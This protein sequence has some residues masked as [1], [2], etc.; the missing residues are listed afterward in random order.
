VS[1]G[2]TMRKLKDLDARIRRD[3][4]LIFLDG[5]CEGKPSQIVDFYGARARRLR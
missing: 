3:A 5:A 2:K 4:D 1:G